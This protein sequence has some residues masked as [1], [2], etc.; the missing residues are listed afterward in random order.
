MLDNALEAT[1]PPSDEHSTVI[2]SCKNRM[3]PLPNS[4]IKSG[5]VLNAKVMN[6]ILELAYVKMLIMQL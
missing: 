6:G 5:I 2:L 3:L 1:E 4:L